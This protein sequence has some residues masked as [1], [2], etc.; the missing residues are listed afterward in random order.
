MAPLD[1]ELA[2]AAR[3]TASF[4]LRGLGPLRLV[5]LAASA[6]RVAHVPR[7]RDEQ[8]QLVFCRR[9][10][11]TTR[12]SGDSFQVTEGEF[13]LLDNR[14]PYEMTISAEHEAIDVVM[15]RAWLE[16]WL[17]DLSTAVSRPISAC[18]S[19]GLPL[20]SL[21]VAMTG[22]L[23]SAPLPRTSLADQLGPLLA[24]AVGHQPIET[25]R[26]RSKLAARILRVIEERYAEPGLDPAAVAKSIGISKRYLHALL[27]DEGETFIGALSRARLEQA[28]SFLADRRFA[29]LQIAEI[30][31]RC[32]Y[33]DPSYFARAFRRRFGMGPK[34]W[35]S[36]QLQ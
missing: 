10:P 3:F 8:F 23:D 5:S 25:T 7:S 30:S 33:Q 28:S 22:E 18:A 4:Q 12:I 35:R 24:L 14:Q 2:D 36:A 9:T 21:L 27:T 15:P 20:G 19:W 31:W 11:I 34:E 32:G 6:Q 26:H 29:Q 17:P 13:I 16:R 1:I